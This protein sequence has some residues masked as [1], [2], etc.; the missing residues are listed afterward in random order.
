MIYL[1]ALRRGARNKNQEICWPFSEQQISTRHPLGLQWAPPELRNWS[2][3][4]ASH[5]NVL[6]F[7]YVIYLEMVPKTE[8]AQR[9]LLLY[10][11]TWESVKG[12]KMYAGGRVGLLSSQCFPDDM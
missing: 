9:Q 7:A 2:V 10:F 5:F 1:R 12:E 8:T 11:I 4:S 6:A 3:S